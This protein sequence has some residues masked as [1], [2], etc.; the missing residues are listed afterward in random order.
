MGHRTTAGVTLVELVIVLAIVGVIAS[1]GATLIARLASEQQSNRGRLTLA[2]SAD[3][4]LNQV[5]DQLQQAL[6]N[7]LRVQS[8]AEGVWI[9]WIPVRD[10]GVARLS[11][12][13]A[14]GNSGDRLDLDDALDASFDVI[15]VPLATPSGSAWIVW[16]NLGTPEADAYAGTNRRAGLAITAGGTRVAFTPA[17][18]LPP[19]NGS[20]RF[21][22]VGAPMSLACRPVAGGGFELVRYS[23][24]GWQAIQ[25]AGAAAV[26]SATADV[27]ASGLQSCQAS[28]S[29]ALANI[30]LL[31]LRVSAQD[32]TSGSQLNLVQQIALDNAP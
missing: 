14:N 21:F 2:Q 28:Y 4:A 26:A 25:P 20:G 17:G 13:T 19:G 12:D 8:N 6:P 9:E 16:Q 3:G 1:L 31:N 30:G 11:A 24:Y 22:I 18:A 7:S 27:M 10:A 29:T 32:A 5:A 15:G 23:G